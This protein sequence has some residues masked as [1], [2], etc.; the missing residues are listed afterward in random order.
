MRAKVDEL[1]PPQNCRFLIITE[2]LLKDLSSEWGPAVLFRVT[3]ND[4][5]VLFLEFDSQPQ[6]DLANL[7]AENE[8]F[9]ADVEEAWEK[10]DELRQLVQIVIDA[11]IFDDVCG[12]MCCDDEQGGCWLR[13]AEK[14]LN[15]KEA[16]RG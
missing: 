12:S 11:K 14:A 7:R 4:G 3:S 15:P 13:R 10:W 1:S 9:V 2:D 6:T 16:S 8:K 5:R